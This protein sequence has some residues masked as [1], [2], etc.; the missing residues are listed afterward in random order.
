MS[1]KLLLRLSVTTHPQTPRHAKQSFAPKGV[2]KQSL[3]TSETL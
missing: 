1:S 2:T 3:G